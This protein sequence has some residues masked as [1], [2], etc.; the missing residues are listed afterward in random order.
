M[1]ETQKLLTAKEASQILRVHPNTLYR[2]MRSGRVPAVK[3]GE[4]NAM[5]KV[6]RE[7]LDKILKGG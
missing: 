1:V 4:K 7:D 5:W 3:I 6:R 2:W